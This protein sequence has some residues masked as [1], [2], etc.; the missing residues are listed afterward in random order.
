MVKV[1]KHS[2]SSYLYLSLKKHSSYKEFKM[3]AYLL[4]FKVYR[5][6]FVGMIISSISLKQTFIELFIAVGQWSKCLEHGKALDTVH[7]LLEEVSLQHSLEYIF[8]IIYALKKNV[9]FPF[10]SEVFGPEKIICY[11]KQLRE[12]KS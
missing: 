6:P 9:D 10:E 12:F 7:F 11:S 5:V 3:V 4:H 2:D 1:N 8:F